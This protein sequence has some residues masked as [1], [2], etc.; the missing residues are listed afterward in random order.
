MKITKEKDAW[1]IAVIIVLTILIMTTEILHW[2]RLS[3]LIGPL[4]LSH[5]LSWTGTIYIAFAVLIIALL[6]RRV[7]KKYQALTRLHIF[8]N[9]LAFMLIS[10]H[11]AGQ[12]SRTPLP[13]L[14]TGVILYFAMVLLVGT[15][16]LQKFHLVT[17]I[18]PRA[19]RFL[20]IGSA[21]V[22]YLIIVVHILHG[23]GLM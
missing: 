19:F 16:T 23:I 13:D 2:V 8:G 6:K 18:K 5:W 3:F 22:F 14:G 17:R 11:F 12:I 1:A 21:I 10:L 15:G 7:P 20:H 9:L 4:R